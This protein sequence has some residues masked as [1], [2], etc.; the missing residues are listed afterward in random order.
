[1]STVTKF[2]LK[3]IKELITGL[4]ENIQIIDHRMTNLENQMTNL[5]NQMTNLENRMTNL[6]QGFQDFEK[7]QIETNTKISMIETSS[8]K[9]PDLAEKVGELKNWKQ[10]GLALFGTLVGG[11]IT[12]LIKMPNP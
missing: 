3:E 7:V 5:E 6:E 4:G 8:Q 1:M 9:I 11:L 10:I 12:Y 2:D